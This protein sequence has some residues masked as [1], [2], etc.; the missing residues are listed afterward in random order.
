MEL[1]LKKTI[2]NL[3]EEGDI[4][5]VKPGFGRNYLIPQ[6]L[7]VLATKSHKAQLETEQEAILARKAQQRQESDDLAKKL[8][9][10]TVTISKRAGEEDKLY[11]SV[12][13]SEIAEKLSEIGIEIDKRKINMDD[14]IKT[15]G[16][17]MVSV[18]VGYQMSTEIK[19][20][21]VAAVEAE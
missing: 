10:I 15:L 13:T 18:K 4:V 1:I 3:G 12:S 14:Q 7:A 21:V 17:T 2:D 6:Q 16:V 5:K 11:G 9:G 20:E 8:S 19:V